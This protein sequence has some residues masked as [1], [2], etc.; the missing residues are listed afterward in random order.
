MLKVLTCDIGG[1]WS[2]K[3]PQCR[4][5]D[6]G[7]PAQI[8]F[9]TVTQLNKTTTVGSLI[10]YNCQNDYWLVG[11]AK[12]ECTREGKWSRDTPSCEC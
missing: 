2:G 12:Q 1:Q 8:E 5:V 3:S 9:G 6:C 7:A 4:F 11:D 10:M